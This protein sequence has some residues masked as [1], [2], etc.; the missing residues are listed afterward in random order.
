MNRESIVKSLILCGG[1]FALGLV[2]LILGRAATS[3]AG[4]LPCSTANVAG[5]YA[6]AASG[7]ILAN[8][9]GFPPGALSSLGL[10]TF[11]RQGRYH[12]EEKVSFNGQLIDWT[13]SGAYTVNPDCT[14]NVVADKGGASALMIFASERKE[15]LGILTNAGT[16]IN[17][18]FRRVD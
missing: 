1:L 4:K 16:A 18:T 6:M 9:F 14:C 5:M 17:L 3:T 11:D 15:A 13:E 8:Q 12:L 10:I 2:L 7:T